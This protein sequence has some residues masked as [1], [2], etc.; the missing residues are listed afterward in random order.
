MDQP[1]RHGKNLFPEN[2][3]HRGPMLPL[4][5]LVGEGPLVIIENAMVF[6]EMPNRSPEDRIVFSDCIRTLRKG[7]D[8]FVLTVGEPTMHPN[9][10][11]SWAN[12]GSVYAPLKDPHDVV[13]FFAAILG[14]DKQARYQRS[15]VFITKDPVFERV[16]KMIASYPNFN[17]SVFVWNWAKNAEKL[18]ESVLLLDS[19]VEKWTVKRRP[20]PPRKSS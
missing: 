12:A 13:A 19:V 8:A 18:K 5:D 17:T 1:K 14:K 10:C 7:G 16:R 9:M 6:D 4:A 2:V 3:L 20:P 11:H 15:F